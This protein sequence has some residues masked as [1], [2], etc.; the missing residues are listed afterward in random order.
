MW[1]NHTSGSMRGRDP[2]GS[3]LLYLIL[4]HFGVRCQA[5]VTDSGDIEGGG[6]RVGD[7]VTVEIVRALRT[8]A[9]AKPVVSERVG[10][11]GA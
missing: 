11:R 7:R 9:T 5:F 8:F 3:L 1:E 2:Q 10:V 4:C 6:S